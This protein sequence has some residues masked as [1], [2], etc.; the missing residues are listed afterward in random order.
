MLMFAFEAVPDKWI[1]P[2]RGP[3][4][5][6]NETREHLT[7]FRAEMLRRKAAHAAMERVESG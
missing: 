6:A 2:L 5:I 3:R 4:F 1:P 7:E